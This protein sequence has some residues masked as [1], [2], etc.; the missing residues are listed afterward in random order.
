MQLE[1][2]ISLQQTHSSVLLANML[3][4][5]QCRPLL[6]MLCTS[7]PSY[8]QLMC[9]RQLDLASKRIESWL[10]AELHSIRTP[11]EPLV[12]HLLPAFVTGL[13]HEVQQLGAHSLSHN[14]L[15][16]LL[17]SAAQRRDG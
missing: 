11:V 14:G 6:L 4:S 13:F 7:G 8:M 17:V 9:V 3:G 2:H 10:R 5:P 16:A 12:P 15:D 1:I